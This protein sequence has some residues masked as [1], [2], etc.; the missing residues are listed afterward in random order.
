MRKKILCYELGTKL[1]LKLQR[2]A[3]QLQLQS[4]LQLKLETTLQGSLQRALQPV[5]LNACRLGPGSSR[6]LYRHTH[7]GC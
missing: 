1:Q 7:S 4:G 3:L 5:S 6:R 2:P